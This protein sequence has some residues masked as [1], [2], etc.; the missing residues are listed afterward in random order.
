MYELN[1]ETFLQLCLQSLCK[2]TRGDSGNLFQHLTWQS[3]VLW[4]GSLSLKC[5]S[6]FSLICFWLVVSFKDFILCRSCRDFST[7]WCWT[8]P[9][10]W[11]V[12]GTIPVLCCPFWVFLLF[13]T[14]SWSLYKWVHDVNK[15][16][17][18]KMRCGVLFGAK[19]KVFLKNRST[20]LVSI[21]R[22][23][24]NPL[25]LYSLDLDQ[26]TNDGNSPPS[27]QL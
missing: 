15:R 11:P 23:V 3:R 17:I 8:A 1:R 26:F 14:Q 9:V 5:A 16:W 22:R 12:F 25:L 6:P 24:I 13:D 21:P 20:F 10:T 2:A 7:L 27:G 18:S 4:T 19:L